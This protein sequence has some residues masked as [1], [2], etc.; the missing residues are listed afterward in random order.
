MESLSEEVLGPRFPFVTIN[1]LAFP[2]FLYIEHNTN[3]EQKQ[4]KRTAFLGNNLVSVSIS[5]LP[6]TNSK[7]YPN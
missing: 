5:Y 3:I 1:L 6:T 7:H 4:P 2:K